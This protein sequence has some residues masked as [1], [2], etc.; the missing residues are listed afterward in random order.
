MNKLI[1]LKDPIFYFALIVA[2]TF[3]SSYTGGIGY[4]LYYPMLFIAFFYNNRSYKKNNLFSVFSL[5]LLTCL[6]SLLFNHTRILPIFQAPFRLMAFSILIIGFTP[7]LSSIKKNIYC[8]RFII[9]S[10]ILLVFIGFINYYSYKT[11][12]IEVSEGNRV[13]A[14]TIGTNFLGTLC[15]IGIIYLTSLLM[16][17]N[18]LNRIILILSII[19]ILGLLICLLLSSS[20]NSIVSVII[21]SLFMFYIKFKRNVNKLISMTAVVSI[22]AIFT[23]PLWKEYTLGIS[24]KQGE[25][26]KE[27]DM[28]SRESYWEDRYIEFKSSPII[29]IG[30]A[31]ISNP[32]EFSKKTG[33]IETT[34]G[35]GSLF[36]QLGFI[37]AF[38]FLSLTIKNL[39]FL[40]KHKKGHYLYCLLIGLLVFFCINSIG[41]GYIT[42]VGCQF[43]IYFWTVQGLIYALRKKYIREDCL[44]IYFLKERK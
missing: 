36:S 4:K 26:Y 15:S 12:A 3:I 7:L 40:L 8:Y 39:I 14:G 18:S 16:F 10:C 17:Y 25:N 38:L 33:I 29:G 42:T 34:T 24:D 27:F 23:F 13:Y 32:S 21:S 20:R 30:F 19:M 6:I 41:E 28:K 35:W 31:N 5:F 2:L 1:F 9:Y 11:G 22:I 43:T 44:N 37:G